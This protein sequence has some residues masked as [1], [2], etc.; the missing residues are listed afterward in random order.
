[1]DRIAF[2]TLLMGLVV[3]VQPVRVELAPDL[4]PA[5]IV[6]YLD[7]SAAGGAAAPPWEARVDFGRELRPHELV[8]AAINA[9]GDRIAS[10][11]RIVNLPAPAARLDILVD[12][13]ARGRPAGA[14]LVASSVRREKPERLSL[15]LDGRPLALDEHGHAALPALDMQQT[16]VLA[17]IAEFAED[18]IARS[19]VALG[20]AIADES[21]SRLTAIPIRVGAGADPTVESLK[22]RFLRGPDAVPV[23]A[24]DKGAATVLLVRHPSAST[25]SRT[26][27]RGT[28]GTGV[29]LDD[30]DRV[31]LVWP[32]SHDERV[33]EQQVRLL[34]AT[35]YFTSRDGG[36]LWVLTRV[37]RQT[38]SR[39]PY[40]YGDAVA[41]AGLLAYQSGT[42]RA[43]VLASTFGD[44]ASQL[45]PAQVGSYLKDLDVPLHLWSF[46]ATETPWGTPET[47]NSF[48]DYQR[49]AK[50]LKE[51]L[52][53]QRIVW[54][55][56]E[57]QPG[58]IDLVPGP[59]G[60]S[61][62]R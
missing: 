7:G 39:P 38:P 4:H 51:D 59:D 12:R 5:G 26:A 32:L 29:R 6:Y 25:A 61:R 31:G 49:A 3:G 28:A 21:G 44:D 2:S 34:E 47:L 20:G 55:A 40:L 54:L 19:D 15:T 13:N 60:I 58:Q 10:V 53:S 62:L 36:L 1:V 37:S 22:G 14:R 11:T 50:A 43:V 24:V 8:A 9:K 17:G 35:P 23:V 46:S 57:W 30:D 45:S 16:H 18:T 48:A 52:D 33:G 41:V 56:G 27:G 42:R